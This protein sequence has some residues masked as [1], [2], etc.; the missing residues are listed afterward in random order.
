MHLMLRKQAASM[1]RAYWAG[2]TSHFSSHLQRSRTVPSLFTSSKSFSGSARGYASQPSAPMEKPSGKG[3]PMT[4]F[5]IGGVAVAAGLF[6]AYQAGVI[7]Q[8][9]DQDGIPIFKSTMSNS[10]QKNSDD[11]KHQKDQTSLSME[12][13]SSPK[14]EE[15]THSSAVEGEDEKSETLADVGHVEKSQNSNIADESHAPVNN[16]TVKIVPLVEEEL[17]SV[18]SND[19]A[20][21]G[22]DSTSP[23]E[24]SSRESLDM[25]DIHSESSKLKTDTVQK[26][27]TVGSQALEESDTKEV[28][29]DDLASKD[30][31]V[32]ENEYQRSGSGLSHA[33]FLVENDAGSLSEDDDADSVIVSEEKEVSAQKFEGLDYVKSSEDGKL[34]L[35]FIEAIH[36]AER[37]QAD[38][39][40]RIYSEEKRWL[41]EKYEKELKDTRARE[42]MYAEEV[43]SL[44]KELNKERAKA[45]AIVKSLQEKAEEK[46]KMEL[47]RKDE[48]VEVQLK[49]AQE[50]AKAE[51][52]AAIAKEKASQ[53]E[54]MTEANLDINALCMAFYART[55][56]A[57]QSHSVHKLAL[58]TLALQDALSKGLPI[59]REIASLQTTLEGID[60][61]SLV[62]HV[63]S[64]LPEETLQQGTYTRSELN[65]KLEALKGTLRH[66]TL[67]PAGGGGVLAHGLAQLAS[68]LKIEEHGDSGEG[69]ECVINRVE[70][71]LAEGKLGDAAN[72]LESGVHGSEAENIIGGWVKQVRNRAVTEQ[73]VMLLQ[74]YA[75]V[76]GST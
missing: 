27:D 59:H 6:A 13:L 36:A 50:L 67:I 56:E 10:N 44:D 75:S 41:K 31:E 73:A 25:G 55:E 48:E 24:T 33:Y 46:L 65:Q 38:L 18:P 12:G 19:K 8:R 76:V 69:I 1:A 22:K 2:T 34:V 4:L 43:A 7:G 62:D 28:P 37:K 17:A 9:H 39:D 42:L 74:S 71:L 11:I 5:V 40:A 51:L 53:L 70:K 23:F 14:R 29:H 45:A 60:K 3:S 68:L 54:K 16:E 57:R 61:D 32:D 20:F 49:K 66:L 63:L 64:S 52:A 26:E 21:G 15:E 58:E 72:S 47:Q 30:T 35:D